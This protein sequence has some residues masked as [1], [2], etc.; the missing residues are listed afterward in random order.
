MRSS[1]LPKC[2][3]KIA[4]SSALPYN[5]LPGQKSLNKFSKLQFE[6]YFKNYQKIEFHVF[7]LKISKYISSKFSRSFEYRGQQLLEVLLPQ[8]K[9]PA[10]PLIFM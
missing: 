9:S 2:Q 4:R 1:F 6:E 7:L 8:E 10:Y 5:K 3:P